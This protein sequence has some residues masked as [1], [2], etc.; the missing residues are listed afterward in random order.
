[1]PKLLAHLWIADRMAGIYP[2][3][4]DPDFYL[5]S[6]APD[7]VYSRNKD[8]QKDKVISHL[9]SS[10]RNWEKNV[11]LSYGAIAEPTLFELGYYMHLITDIKFHSVMRQ[12]Y[13]L[14][15]VSKDKRSYYESLI[16][17]L[18]LRMLFDS[19]QAYM[20]CVNFTKQYKTDNFPFTITK[21]DI[22]N[23]FIY[24]ENIFDIKKVLIAKE[25]LDIPLPDYRAM[26]GRIIKYLQSVFF[27]E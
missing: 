14:N 15:K 8:V 23:N 26:C 9:M 20:D 5:G 27:I 11:M 2:R 1:M 10:K 25:G 13:N 22:E 24:A 16:I 18:C 7:A 3:L 12:Y 17:P 19:E 6:I 4:K 21:T